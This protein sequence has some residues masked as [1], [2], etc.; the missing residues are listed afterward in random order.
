MANFDLYFP[1]V[2]QFEGTVYENDPTDKGGCT[3][4]GIILDD[5]KEFH[6]DKNKDGKYTC[7]DVMALTKDDA[8]LMY[9]KMYWDYFQ[10]DK[11]ENQTLAEYIVDSAINQGKG[12]IARYIQGILGLATDG[13]VG[14]VT[15]SAINSCN[16]K[17]LY[18]K[19][20]EKRIDRYNQ[21]VKANPSQSKFIKGW[22][23]RVNAISYTA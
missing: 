7:E 21:I 5:L 15:L 16:P 1:K 19:L 18:D 8:K 13:L 3:H 17:D 10:A 14:K 6:V 12:L 20:K 23:N 11:I 22:M 9:K 4:F 2:L